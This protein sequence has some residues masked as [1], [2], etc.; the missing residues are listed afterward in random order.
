MLPQILDYFIVGQGNLVGRE[1]SDRVGHDPSPYCIDFML[2][3]TGEERRACLDDAK[4][5]REEGSCPWIEG[6][7]IDL[8]N[9]S[10]GLEGGTIVSRSTQ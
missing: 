3:G 8:K 9:L 10:C 5:E 1:F 6:R 4:E 2:V 7:R